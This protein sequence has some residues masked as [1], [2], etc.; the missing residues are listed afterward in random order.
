VTPPVLICYDR[1]AGAHHAIEHAGALF[2]GRRAI[3]LTLWELPLELPAYGLD[4]S[5]EVPRS[6]AEQ[7]VA[8]GCE[9]AR[10]CG[11]DPEPVTSC[12]SVD[13]TWQTILSIAR[14]RGASVIVVGAR[15]LHGVKSLVLGSVSRDVVLH[16]DR[17]VLVVPPGAG[18]VEDAADGS[19]RDVRKI[20][21]P[22]A[23]PHR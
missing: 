16:A 7:A 20:R 11:L 4:I 5:D 3:V 1:S 15:G 9:L 12:G 13:G 17:P 18:S 23:S 21:T 8:E 10:G 22:I 14:D 2:P 6:L 19:S